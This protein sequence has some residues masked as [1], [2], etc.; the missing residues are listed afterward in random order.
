MLMILKLRYLVIIVI[1][2]PKSGIVYYMNERLEKNLRKIKQIVNKKDRDYVLAIDGDEGSGKSVIGMQVGFFLDPTLTL[3]RV[4][5]NGN[6]LI[7]AVSNAKKG[8]C[9][10]YDE[11]YSGL[12]SRGALSEINHLIVSMMTEMRQK[13]LFIIIVLPTFFMLDKYVS[14]WRSRSL[15]HVYMKNGRRGNYAVFNKR[16]KKYLYLYGKKEYNYNVCKSTFRGRFTDVYVVDEK[17]YREKHK[18]AL[19]SKDRT[20]KGE[21]YMEHRNQLIGYIVNK[22]DLS[23]SDMEKVCKELDISLKK[24]QLHDILKKIK[25]SER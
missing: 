20:T 15:I 9:I 16:Q 7:R 6:E 24:T 14:L 19:E 25:H 13:N 18:K 5:M 1:V 4:C 2:E 22:M 23:L 21:K 12:S 17:K 8:Q 11:A 3:D 10:I